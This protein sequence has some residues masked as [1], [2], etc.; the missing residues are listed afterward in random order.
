[1]MITIIPAI[2]LKDGKCVRLKQGVA[3]D[4]TV[5]SDSPSEMAKHWQKE[6]G[7]FLHVVDLDGAF[8]GKPVHFEELKAICKTV[9]IPVEIGGG[10]RTDEDI[11]NLL[12]T[13][14]SRVILG[15]RACE[16]PEELTRLVE[17][18][19]G[20]K[21]AVGIDARDGKVQT[22]GWVETT[23]VNAVDLAKKVDAAGVG[24]IIYTDTSRDGMMDGVNAFEMGKICSA[25]KCDVVASGGVSNVEDIKRLVALNCDNLTGAIVGK[26]LYEET[27]T[28]RQLKKAAK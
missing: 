28:V 16:H 14:V 19:G 26:A 1:M 3:S 2:D 5:Y 27:V 10:I 18:F 15:T 9:H 7:E 21:I 13:G 20:D 25:V 22:K 8:D 4:E 17:K 6:G 11:E 24:T 12:A 23:D